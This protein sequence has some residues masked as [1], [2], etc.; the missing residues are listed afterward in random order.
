MQQSAWELSI[1][2]RKRSAGRA[3][4]VQKVRPDGNS[5][6]TQLCGYLTE[7]G[8]NDS[9]RILLH[10]L[11]SH[12]DTSD[13]R[14]A[15]PNTP[16]F[17][18]RTELAAHQPQRLPPKHRSSPPRLHLTLPWAIFMHTQWK[19]RLGGGGVGRPSSAR[20]GAAGSGAKHRAAQCC[21]LNPP[22]EEG[23]NPAPLSHVVPNLDGCIQ[24]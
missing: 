21:D 22:R 7:K 10:D 16:T 13:L 14:A 4:P 11:S 17:N 20:R 18:V 15:A 9:S 12:S 8:I 1:F 6:P 3:R 2:I 23:T 5:D 24:M 19:Y